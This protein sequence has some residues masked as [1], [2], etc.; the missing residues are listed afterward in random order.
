VEA[1][2]V[3][4]DRRIVSGSSDGAVRV[5]DPNVSPDPLILQG[6]TDWVRAVAVLPDGR[7]LSGSDDRTVRVWDLE[8]GV[9]TTMRVG[10]PVRA[11]TL[12]VAGDRD[13]LVIAQDSGMLAVDLLPG[14]G[15]VANP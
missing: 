3:L 6:H 5:W 13:R 7:V 8:T 4:S 12:G 15:K 10:E 9:S 1:L 14:M 2:A 11:L